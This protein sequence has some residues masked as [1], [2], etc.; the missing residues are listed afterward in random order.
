MKRFFDHIEEYLILIILSLI[1]IITFV[2][3]ILR[4]FIKAPLAYIEQLVPGLFVWLTFI[5]LV[6]ALKRR[7]H[8][9]IAIV[10]EKFPKIA[11][12]VIKVLILLLSIIFFCVVGIYG[13]KVL[14]ISLKNKQYMALGIPSWIIKLAIPFGSLLF[15]IRT[16]QIFIKD[17]KDSEFFLRGNH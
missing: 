4:Y 11:Q 1:A 6:S 13:Y 5:G 2:G 10:L 9:G 7:S 16:V 14:V 3:V 12:L 17:V 15:I 8:L